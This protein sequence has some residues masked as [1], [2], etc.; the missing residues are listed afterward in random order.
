MS[1]VKA[2][3][4]SFGETWLTNPADGKKAALLDQF[5]DGAIGNK[6]QAAGAQNLGTQRHEISGV[7][8]VND[9]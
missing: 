6:Q 1:C 8:T 7:V 2:E 3:R 5:E 4:G 9:L